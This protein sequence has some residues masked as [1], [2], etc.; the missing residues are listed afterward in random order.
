MGCNVYCYH[1]AWPV[2]DF[3]PFVTVG[4]NSQLPSLVQ[5]SSASARFPAALE[6]SRLLNTNV[7]I[8]MLLPHSQEEPWLWFQLVSPHCPN[9]SSGAAGKRNHSDFYT[10]H[11][12]YA[13]SL[14]LILLIPV[15]ICTLLVLCVVAMIDCTN[16]LHFKRWPSNGH[17]E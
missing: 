12:W 11:C 16:G 9:P 10:A 3:Q 17:L 13:S 4:W 5:A 1:C 14:S 6:S 7:F 15:F 8:F 2:S